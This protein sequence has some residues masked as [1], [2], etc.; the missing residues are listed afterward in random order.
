MIAEINRRHAH[1]LEHIRDFI[2]LHYKLSARSDSEFW[3]H[4]QSMEIPDT[5]AHKIDLFKSCGQILMHQPEAF[6]E[7]SWLTMYQGFAVIP[8][9]Y[10]HRVDQFSLDEIAQQFAQMHRLLNSAGMQADAHNDFINKYCASTEG[11]D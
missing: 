6:R 2:I 9:R 5:L 7:A 11:T 8:E 1:E 4:C 3:R 10:D